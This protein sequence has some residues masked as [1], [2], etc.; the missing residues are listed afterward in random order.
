MFYDALNSV[1]LHELCES[2]DFATHLMR[3]LGL[4]RL[5]LK[6]PTDAAPGNRLQEDLPGVHAQ[7]GENHS[8]CC[9]GAV[10]SNWAL[11]A[12]TG[13]KT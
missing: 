4:A 2:I 9:I 10:S 12:V 5:P 11:L 13:F 1:E 7:P 3:G 6:K 8:R